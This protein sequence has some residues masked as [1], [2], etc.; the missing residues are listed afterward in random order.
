M[1]TSRFKVLKRNGKV[2]KIQGFLGVIQMNLGVQDV[3][4]GVQDV[5]AWLEHIRKLDELIRAKHAEYYQLL[6]MAT[7]VTPSFDGMP[8]GSGVSDKV[9][10]IAVKLADLANETNRIWDYYIDQRNAAIAVLEKLP[11]AEY[12]VLHREYVQGKTQEVIASEMGYS[13][14]QI[15]RIK[16]NA[17]EL[18]KKM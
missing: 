9:G 13:T 6:D 3:H 1:D 5:Q 18:L 4:D 14:V 16:Q 10:N 12:G 17:M 15:W 7:R 8:H 2:P 11:A